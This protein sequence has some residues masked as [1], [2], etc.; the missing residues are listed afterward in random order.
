MRTPET[1]SSPWALG[2]K[3]PDGSGAP[4]ELVPGEGHAAA[5]A[6]A[7]VAEHHLLHV[8]SRAPLVGDVVD[9]P[10]GD[11]ARPLPGVEHRPDRAAQLLPRVGGELVQALELERQLA[12]GHRVELG[13][14]R[15][16]ALRLGGGD[17]VLK[18]L[19]GDPGD[20]VAVHLHEPPVAVPGE[21]LVP[22]AGRQAFDCV[23]VEAEVED[24]VEHPRH[25]LAGAG[26]DRHEQRIGAVP[27]TTSGE[28]L[29]ARQR[30]LDLL[31]QPLRELTRTEIG[32]AG[33]GRDGEA[34][35][36]PC[37]SEHAC[38][39]GDVGPLPTE[40]LA[41]PPRAV[42]EVHHPT[43]GALRARARSCAGAVAEPL[44]CGHGNAHSA[45][46]G[47]ADLG[48]PRGRPASG[49]LKAG[50][51]SLQRGGHALAEV[52]GRT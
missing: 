27:E 35:R 9:A 7:E 22:G 47:S 10:V 20:D 37:G 11:R 32:D 15:H 13:V 52:G 30:T 45:P 44:L 29:Q 34:R 8:H 17:R 16:A 51:P 2:R 50:G 19:T 25:R 6:L 31:E 12:Q 21:A 33:L 48:D 43:R 46:H 14:Q 3:S 18:V 28:R 36:N 38:H 41:H 49:P 4:V 5:A 26:A 24:R 39:L 23:V 40:Q 42:L 1:T